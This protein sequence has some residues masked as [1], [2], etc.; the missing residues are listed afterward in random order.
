MVMPTAALEAH[1]Q[2]MMDLYCFLDMSHDRSHVETVRDNVVKLCN[3]ELRQDLQLLA[4]I[5]AVY[6][7]VCLGDGRDG[8]ELRAQHRVLHDSV[9]IK[10]LTLDE[11]VAVAYAVRHH[12]ASTGRPTTMLEK[13]VADADRIPTDASHAFMRAFEYG[14]ANYPELSHEDQLRRSAAH[15]YAKYGKPG[16]YTAQLDGTRTLVDQI[17]LPIFLAHRS[18][19]VEVMQR[20]LDG[21]EAAPP[22]AWWKTPVLLTSVWGLALLS[23]YAAFSL[24]MV[25]FTVEAYVGANFATLATFMLVLSFFAICKAVDI[26]KM[27]L[28]T[29]LQV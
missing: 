10:H 16:G 27:T 1:L 9:L 24:L 7:D 23:C 28:T 17:M 25:S 11:R 3:Q 2:E 26:T 19:D 18:D 29:Q 8:H 14:L 15:L 13:I 4:E 6:H 5:A 20:I 12:R 22:A 21:E